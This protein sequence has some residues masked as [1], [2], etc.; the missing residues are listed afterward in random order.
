MLAVV[1]HFA[2]D[3]A[4]CDPAA[5][6]DPMSPAQCLRPRPLGRDDAEALRAL[7]NEPGITGANE[8]LSVPFTLRDALQ[9]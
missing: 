9:S 4:A 1:G 6:R 3:A 7:T 8:F 2:G 5:G